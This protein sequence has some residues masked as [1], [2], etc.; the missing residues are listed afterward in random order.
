MAFGRSRNSWDTPQRRAFGARIREARVTR[1]AS[2][3]SFAKALQV[4]P[5]YISQIE[6]G[7]RIPSDELLCGMAQVLPEA[8]DWAAMRVE[9]HRLRSPQD[10]AA[11][12]IS[13]PDPTPGISND[14]LFQRLRI[15]LEHSDLPPERRSK[16]IEGWL[17]EIHLVRQRLDGDSNRRLK[18]VA[19]G[20]SR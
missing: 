13:P 3:E 2:Q 10:L 7:R 9:A 18:R 14:Q 19:R 1:F 6:S 16:M 12:V 5:P 8:V 4:A 15:Q 11:L 20:S 17:E